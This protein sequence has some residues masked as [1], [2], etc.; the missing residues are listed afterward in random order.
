MRSHARNIS[1][2][3]GSVRT[4]GEVNIPSCLAGN[5]VVVR[6]LV[7]NGKVPFLLSDKIIRLLGGDVLNSEGQMSWTLLGVKQNIIYTKTGHSLVPCDEFS[8]PA[9]A[10]TF[11]SCHDMGDKVRAFDE[12]GDRVLACVPEDE[13]GGICTVVC[14]DQHVESEQGDN[15]ASTTNLNMC[16]ENVLLNAE[17]PDS[18]AC[19]NISDNILACE[20]TCVGNSQKGTQ[21]RWMKKDKDAAIRNILA[22]ELA[23]EQTNAQLPNSNQPSV[24]TDNHAV[25]DVHVTCGSGTGASQSLG[26]GSP[27][28]IHSGD[29]EVLVTGDQ[30]CRTWSQNKQ[31]KDAEQERSTG[32][33]SQSAED[34]IDRQRDESE[35]AEVDCGGKAKGGHT[36]FGSNCDIRQV[37]GTDICEG[38]TG[39]G[40]QRLG[41][42]N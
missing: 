22:Q 5:M 7:I 8:G 19:E 27:N 15:D 40:I 30:G 29:V 32:G 14:S 39:S 28:R 10:K 42:D 16:D 3:G 17:S 13:S 18:P 31:R 38:G 24:E 23:S 34:P 9:P 1:G 21:H 36:T 33:I 4:L 2:V 11:S 25:F 6:A 37:Q 41:E 26:A 12:Q 35:T 20:Q